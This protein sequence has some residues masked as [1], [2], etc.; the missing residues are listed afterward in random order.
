MKIWRPG[1]EVYSGEIAM[2]II[3]CVIEL[4]GTVTY[5]CVYWDGT[6]RKQIWAYEHELTSDATKTE[7]RFK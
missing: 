7:I 2:L 5:S 3:K 1:T 6:Q 4:G